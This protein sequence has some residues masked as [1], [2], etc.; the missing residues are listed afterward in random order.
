MG[1]RMRGVRTTVFTVALVVAGVSAAGP[2]LAQPATGLPPGAAAENIRVVGYSDLD[3]RAGAFKMSILERGGRW[4]LYLGQFS[5]GKL[6][7]QTED[8]LVDAR[9]YIYITQKNQGVW[10]LQ[11]T[12][13][14]GK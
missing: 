7:V 2:V 9:G 12:G 13:D 3:G 1:E 8:V 10:V 11:Y 5:Q 14:P 6:V 4:Y